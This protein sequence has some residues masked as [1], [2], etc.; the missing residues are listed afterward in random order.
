MNTNDPTVHATDEEILAGIRRHLSDVEPLVPRPPARGREAVSARTAV[1][2]S[3]RSRVVFAGLAPLVLV[4]ALVVVAVGVGL[5]GRQGGTG[6]SPDGSR[7]ATIVY[8]LTPAVGQQVTE[9][10]LDTTA[11][12][13]RGRLSAMGVTTAT[14]TKVPPNRVSVHVVGDAPIDPLPGNV[15]S[16]RGYLNTPYRLEFVPLPPETYGTSVAAGSVA[17]PEPGQGVDGALPALL[18]GGDVDPSGVAAEV[19]LAS[20]HTDTWAV[21]TH[22]KS[23]AA[24]TFKSWT[25]THINEYLAIAMDGTV[26]AVSL[27]GAQIADGAVTIRGGFTET[28]ARWLADMIRIGTLPVPVQEVSYT[29]SY[30]IDGQNGV[31]AVTSAPLPSIAAPS[32]QTPTDIPASGRTLGNPDAPVTIEV[33]VDYQCAA[34]RQFVQE[35]LPQ[36]IEKYVRPGKAKVVVHDFI[37]IDLN[38]GGQ[39]SADAANAARCAADQGKFWAYQD[40]LW[41]N[42]VAEGSGTFSQDR[43]IQ[44]GRLA[45]LDMTS[46]QSCVEGGTHL[47]DVR[48]ESASAQ[49]ASIVGAPA[50]LVQ[51]QVLTAYDYA[52]VA[53]AI[54]GVLPTAAPSPRASAVPSVAGVPRDA[55]SF[56]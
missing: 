14:V 17:V 22:F 18:G 6:T 11:T 8:Q 53:T 31:P 2:T 43:L 24:A 23:E 46:F 32:A 4:V 35:I 41:A 7:W 3:V 56:G 52:T 37:V 16:V 38:T 44:I 20:S 36:L 28:D 15:R 13:M 55:I 40:W 54:D 19:D 10:E 33:W 48:A 25:G 49:S 51:G 39:E 1:R 5:G 34:C 45:A 21:T 47:A 26:L 12:I 50:I 27:I 29:A 9:A 42:Q 30:P